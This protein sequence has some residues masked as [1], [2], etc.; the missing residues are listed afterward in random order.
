V[1]IRK[2][3]GRREVA[4]VCDGMGSHRAGARASHTALD[5]VVRALTEGKDLADGFRHAND[6]VRE[7]ARSEPSKKGM[8]TTMVAL[9]REDDIYWVGNLGDS[10]A[11]R[12]DAGGI[13]QIT[14]DHSFVAEAVQAGEMTPDE[15]ARSPWRNAI[16]RILGAEAQVEVDLFGEFSAREP[17]VVILCTDGLHGVLTEQDIER[18]ARQASDIR[19]VAR[20]LCDEAIRRGGKDNV[21]VAAMAFGDVAGPGFGA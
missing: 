9:L 17:H 15:A 14:R 19:D 11:Y 10:R 12:I 16:T 7:E 18:T 1:A 2:I 5:A 6:A 4:V 21:T 8:G 3:S 20:A 13:R